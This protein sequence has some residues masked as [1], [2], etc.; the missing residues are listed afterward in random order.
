MC[1]TN[2]LLWQSRLDIKFKLLTLGNFKHP[3]IIAGV[4]ASCSNLSEIPTDFLRLSLCIVVPV[5]NRILCVL[6]ISWKVDSLT[7]QMSDICWGSHYVALAGLELLPQPPKC[8]DYRCV[9]PA[10]TDGCWLTHVGEFDLVILG[11]CHWDLE[12]RNMPKDLCL[13]HS[14]VTGLHMCPSFSCSNFWHWF[15][16]ELSVVGKGSRIT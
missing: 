6:F 2:T 12:R 11:L 10:Q 4:C 14:L 7:S 3:I 16:W 5:L 8:W 1:I 13:I 9:P 15:S